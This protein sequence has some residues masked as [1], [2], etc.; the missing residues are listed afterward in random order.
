MPFLVQIPAALGNG[1][2]AD[3]Q[4]WQRWR[5]RHLMGPTQWPVGFEIGFAHRRFGR[6]PGPRFLDEHGST[7]A[8][9]TVPTAGPCGTTV[10]H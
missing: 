10:Y 5:L 7:E 4:V 2:S 9:G 3:G 1:R 8:G 6:W